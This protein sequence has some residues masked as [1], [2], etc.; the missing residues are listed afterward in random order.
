MITVSCVSCGRPAQE[1]ADVAHHRCL[2]CG[3]ILEAR[4]AQQDVQP[5]P[6]SRY[7]HSL[8]RYRGR[9]PIDP[10]A[11]PVTLGEGMT[12]LR[13]CPQLDDL[14]DSSVRIWV[15][16]ETNN[17][18]G[19][20]KDRLVSVAITHAREQGAS[21]VTCASSGNAA[22]STAAYAASAGMQS[23]VFVPAST[24]LAKVDQARA[25]GAR[26]VAVPGDYS[27]CYLVCA[28]AAK[29]FGWPNLT[30]TYLNPYGT[31][32]LA[33]VGYELV[34]QFAAEGE[35]MDLVSIPLGSGPLLYGID[36]GWREAA[37]ADTS[38]DMSLLGVQ[39]EGCAPIVS[40][41]IA[42]HEAVTPWDKP[43]TIASGI[44]DPLRGY[45]EDGTLTLRLI[46]RRGGSALAVTDAS[47]VWAAEQ[48]AQKAGVL[49]EPTG[50]A[51]L[52]GVAAHLK[53]AT[54]PRSANVAIC[55]TGHG[56]KDPGH[57]PP[58]AHSTISLTQPDAA[59][60]TAEVSEESDERQLEQLQRLQALLGLEEELA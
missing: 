11:T 59:V 24:P 56:F 53:V 34:D 17:P 43:T 52:A 49:A 27:N 25:Y 60:I 2:S 29:Q 8:W 18:T 39:A 7:P 19:S 30:T 44:S 4:S 32:G 23:V 45:P 40:A 6:D 20:F 31:A 3:D 41:F 12:P 37:P 21:V 5:E 15:K 58:A 28:A 22:A 42:G 47:I 9:L 13:R 1:R 48:L 33:T 16:D 14:F 55:V 35:S 57:T 46:R 50:A 38:E 26:V 10:S 36:R 51:S 54:L